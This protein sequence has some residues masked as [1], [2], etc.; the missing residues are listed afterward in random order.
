MGMQEEVIIY[1]EELAASKTKSKRGEKKTK[2]EVGLQMLE[3]YTSQM[4]LPWIDGIN[5]QQELREWLETD[6]FKTVLAAV[7][8]ISSSLYD[9]VD[10]VFRRVWKV[11]AEL[12]METDSRKEMT[13][14]LVKPIASIFFAAVMLRAYF[15]LC[16]QGKTMGNNI[17]ITVDE[18]RVSPL[19]F[20]TAKSKAKNIGLPYNI[21][22]D[23]VVEFPKM[24][25][26]LEKI[27]SEL[28]A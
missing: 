28:G 26:A 24:E 12:V 15:S 3:G 27:K 9:E 11:Y 25:K 10:P 7:L 16:K 18:T 17:P 8:F 19:F 21:S 13:N 14:D 1:L 2:L 20:N 23:L 5:R 6:L 4:I 22:G